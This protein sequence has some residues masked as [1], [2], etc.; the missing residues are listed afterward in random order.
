MAAVVGLVAFY[1]VRLARARN[2]AVAEAARTQRIQ[3]FMMSLF[4]GGDEVV[5]PADS[6]RVVTLV[7]RGVQEARGL[8]AEPAVQAELL[9]RWA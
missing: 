3:R 1:T 9:R 6:L 2:A 4:E 8:A 5:G 7:D